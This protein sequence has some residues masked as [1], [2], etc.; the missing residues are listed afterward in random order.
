MKIGLDVD[1]VIFDAERAYRTSAEIFTLDVLGAKQDKLI[2]KNEISVDIRMGW[3]KE[4]T[5]NWL[6]E[7]L[8]NI[9]R[10]VNFM[11]GALEVIQKLKDMG[12]KLYIIT[13]RGGDFKEM[14][15]ITLDKFKEVNLELDGYFFAIKDKGQV[16]REND[17]DILIDD[18]L[19]HCKSACEKGIK[20][21]YFR[22]VNIEKFNHELCKEVNN[23]GEIYK[24]FKLNVEE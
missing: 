2:N 18:S 11:P 15:D 23:W 21:L 19:N 5:R 7:Y 9:A 14:K 16:C 8:L 24:Y 4:E 22:D 6:N 10:N 20:A 13:A 17:I 3:T 12:H 1:G